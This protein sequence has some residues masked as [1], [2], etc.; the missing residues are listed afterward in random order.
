MSLREKCNLRIKSQFTPLALRIS[1]QKQSFLDQSQQKKQSELNLA[2][3]SDNSQVLLQN[4]G[5]FSH[6]LANFPIQ[7][8]QESTI[9][10]LKNS[11]LV[12]EKTQ[13]TIQGG[14]FSKITGW[15]KNKLKTKARYA[16]LRLINRFGFNIPYRY[17]WGNNSWKSKILSS[18]TFQWHSW[19]YQSPRPRSPNFQIRFNADLREGK[20]DARTYSLKRY[21]SS[22]KPHESTK[23]YQFTK[24]ASRRLDLLPSEKIKDQKW[25]KVTVNKKDYKTQKIKGNAFIKGK[26]DPHVVDPNDVEQGKIA[27]CYLLAAMASVARANPDALQRLIRP[28]GK[29]VYDVTIYINSNAN[30]KPGEGE[31]TPIV[32]TVDDTFPTSSNGEEAFASRGDVNAAG[33]P[34]LWVMLIEKAYAT[35]KGS[36]DASAWGNPGEAMATLTG[37]RSDTYYTNKWTDKQTAKMIENSLAKSLPVT[38]STP[39]MSETMKEQARTINPGIG[40]KHAYS[41]KKVNP[42][43][44]TISLQNPW[45]SSYDVNNLKI[46]EFRRFYNKFQIGR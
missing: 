22:G 3:N 46:S 25:K 15:I 17:R 40:E 13:P 42:D 9:T 14:F 45:G 21:Q 19:K 16:A 23:K 6:N 33:K 10:P 11:Q 41:V 7:S 5:H 30:A 39:A 1:L 20:I 37:N 32:I 29:G 36:Y 31:R 43:S 28:K 24:V 2:M 8:R 26:Y 38:A 34:E 27:N 44:L 12:G 4:I 35:Y 18:N